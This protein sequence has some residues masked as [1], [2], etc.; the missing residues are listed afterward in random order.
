MSFET[1]GF[2]KAAVILRNWLVQSF[3]G[4][5]MRF[6]QTLEEKSFGG[7]YC[8]IDTSAASSI[9]MQSLCLVFVLFRQVLNAMK[10][11]LPA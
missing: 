9:R 5:G 7:Y 2:K 6:L 8:A 1:V 3:R 4:F 10:E 11:P